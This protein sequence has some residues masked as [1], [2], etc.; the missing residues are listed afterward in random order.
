[1][2]NTLT[3]LLL[4]FTMVVFSQNDYT[5]VMDLLLKNE[6]QE[7]RKLYDKKFASK[8]ASDI[9]L[10]FLDAIID[11][12]LG[13]TNF[14]E[15]LLRKIENLPN[16]AFYID[17]FINE[18]YVLNDLSSDNSND[19][20]YKKIDFL[21]AS[22]KFKNKNIVKYRKA[23]YD[24]KRLNF[25]ASLNHYKSLHTINN[26]QLCGVFEN[27]NSSGLDTEYEPELY[28]KDD[29]LFDA[30]SNG[31]VGWFIPKTKSTQGYQYF[32]NEKEY[33]NGIIYAQ[34]FVNV[35]SDKKY[36]LQFG[37]SSGIKIFIDD[38][39]IASKYETAETNLDA[40]NYEIDLQKGIHRI[41]VKLEVEGGS[42]YFSC[43]LFNVDQTVAEEL[44]FEEK[45]IPY[46]S[47][48]FNSASS[49][50]KALDYEEFFESKVKSNPNNVLYKLFLY[51]AYAANKKKDKA[52]DAIEG[53]D[54]RYP[55]SSLIAKYFMNYYILDDNSQKYEEFK[56]NIENN[57]KDY[58]YT[59]V[60]KMKDNNWLQKGSISELE[61][62]Y[63]KSKQYP[64][65]FYSQ[66]FDFMIKSRKS[67]IDGMF[68]LVNQILD[69]SYNNEEYKILVAN[70]YRRLKNDKT[71][72]LQILETLS[73]ERDNIKATYAL[74]DIYNNANQID[75]VKELLREEINKRPDFNFLRTAYI[76]IL[77]DENN[78]KEALELVDINL[79]YFP[80][81]FENFEKK[82]AI[83]SLMN[84]RKE[85][86]KYYKKALSHYSSNSSLRKKL[87]DLTNTPDEIAEV[88]TKDVYAFI[89]KNRNTTLKGD[90]GI[91]ILLDE[92]IV[93][94]LP[95]GGRKSKSKLVYE[96]TSESGI[97]NLKEYGLDSYGINL[98]KSEIIKKNGS[99]VPGEVGSGTIVFSNLEIGDVIYV[100]YDFISNSYGRFYKDF[101]IDYV[102]NGSYPIVES[103]FY[104]IHAPGLKFNTV[105]KNGDLKMVEKKVND[106]IVKQWTQ[107]NLS[108]MPVHESYS[109]NF[110]DLT[111]E[112]Y[113]G[114]IPAWKDIANWYADLVKKNKKVDKTTLA[115][116]NEIFPNGIS[117]LTETQR[118]E[119]IYDY[120]QENITYSYLD[121]RQSGYVPQKP[122]KTLESKLGD[123]K[124]LSTLFV[125][126]AEKADLK[127]NLVL[128]LTNDNGL[129]ALPL[130]SSEFNHCIVKVTLENKDYFIEMTDKYLPF[131][132]MPISLYKANALVIEFDKA[133]NEEAKLIHLNF[134]NSLTNVKKSV[135]EIDITE[136]KKNFKINHDYSGYLKA[137]YNELFSNAISEEIRKKEFENNFNSSLNKT[138]VYKNSNLLSKNKFDSTIQF[139]IQFLVN[140]KLQ[141]LGS[142]KIVEIPFFEKIYTKD[143]IN[144]ETRNYPI[145][146]VKYENVNLYESQVVLNIPEGKKF[147]EIPENKKLAYKNDS[148]EITYE[149]VSDTQLVVNRKANLS[150]E[151]VSAEEYP[152]FKKYVEEVIVSEERIVGYK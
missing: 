15:T 101:N 53:L 66:L 54:I 146:Y 5:E 29:K 138:I 49:T 93:N 45:Y 21:A 111:I 11:V 55:K 26:W 107:R 103:N 19:L 25:E 81:S 128:V 7:A 65:K 1:M 135:V 94:I 129:K 147:I 60:I 18:N 109:P 85:A 59:T 57:D 131:K 56:I 141:Q 80:Y 114:T 118:A 98:T 8:S 47:G 12:E 90:Y 6:R 140:E 112:I 36:L 32:V 88:E 74:I 110:D 69:E 2:K 134:D 39:E 99:I 149:L 4:F 23:F 30:N 14:D 126:L 3:A 92:F 17:P 13:K 142:L 73:K 28:A 35:P 70:L 116:F 144:T 127:S 150:W 75:K 71:K 104:I 64:E 43:S 78:Y 86:E 133:K 106:K 143:L 41:L 77:I 44:T 48:A 67:D 137:Y 87:Y 97:E 84:N 151:D 125:T 121:F 40:F 27:L 82:A 91:T 62:Y 152:E 61:E 68:K 51:S 16:A 120:I 145:N 50:E 46:Q 24:F 123:C 31:L 63:N 136:E 76:D 130:P 139:D 9:D 132:S 38:V 20:I 105:V 42:D 100:E 72:A 102:V 89:K 96:I 33:G 119:K 22:A 113:A 79:E 10:L 148:Y 122:S 52:H 95:E 117:G 34:T 124:D 83:Y 108:A 37:C 115:V 58:Y